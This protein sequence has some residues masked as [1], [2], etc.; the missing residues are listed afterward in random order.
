[1]IPAPTWTPTPGEYHGDLA[2]WSPSMFAVWRES[3]ALALGRF[4][5]RRWPAPEPSWSMV[6]GSA[7]NA[8]LLGLWERQIYVAPVDGRGN[9]TFRTAQQGRP[10]KLVITQAE[11]EL[12][13]EIADAILEPQTEAAELARAL[14]VDAP[15]FS[16]WAQRW[17]EPSGL[18]LKQMTDRAVWLLGRPAVVELKTAMDPSPSRFRW[19]AR[20]YDYAHQLAHN[21]RGLRRAC[22]GEQPDT[23]LVAVRNAPPF[24]V[25]V[26]RPSA[27]ALDRIEEQ[28][29]REIVEV[30]EALRRP[31]RRVWCAAWEKM[32]EGQ[33]PEL[34]LG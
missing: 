2:H 10:E 30:A 12:A 16:E 27:E 32:N 15:G 25:V 21:R 28:L 17:E 23:Y 13:R 5:T 14:L 6:A 9:K 24:E 22:G 26:Y 34:E 31:E 19:S 8:A 7:V 18:G 20:E 29:E 33:I 3:P 4:V 1:M 11:A